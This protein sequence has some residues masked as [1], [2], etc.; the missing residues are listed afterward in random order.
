MCKCIY[1][2]IHIC[3]YVGTFPESN[4]TYKHHPQFL[5]RLIKIHEMPELLSHF[6]QISHLS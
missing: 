6:L 4:N 3:I 1:I 2:H 5:Q